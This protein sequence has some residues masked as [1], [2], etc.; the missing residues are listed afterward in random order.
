MPTSAKR[1]QDRK[2]KSPAGRGRRSATSASAWRASS[3]INQ[4]FLLT[5][6]SGNKAKVKRPGLE[7]M[8]A[9]GDIPDSLLGIAQGAIDKGQG[10]RPDQVLDDKAAAEIAVDPSKWTEML[11]S[12]E[13]IV[14]KVVVEPKVE[15]SK[16]P[17]EEGSD[18]METIPEEDRFEDVLYTDEIELDD[19]F[20]V[21][22]FACG[23]SADLERFRQEHSGS[24]E[25][26]LNGGEVQQPSE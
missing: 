12:V 6:P 8:I 25:R 15:Y 24:V 23:D 10:K 14:A 5:L 1:P 20:F 2:K 3:S 18:E 17:V 16:R 21:F 9:G 22:D 19:K 7:A 11:D 4:T 26:I 13:R